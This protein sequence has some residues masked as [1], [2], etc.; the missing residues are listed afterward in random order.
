MVRSDCDWSSD[1][2]SSDLREV[3]DERDTEATMEQVAA[4]RV[5]R[6]V[7][8]GVAQ[9]TVVVRRRAADVHP[10]AALLPRPKRSLPPGARVV[11]LEGHRAR[12]HRTGAI[13]SLARPRAERWSLL[14]GEGRNLFAPTRFVDASRADGSAEDSR[15]RK[16]E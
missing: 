9:V 15:L 6:N 10:N 11:Q 16:A 13:K 14:D 2:C 4:D 7:R 12:C 1:V 3:L 8:S 5:E